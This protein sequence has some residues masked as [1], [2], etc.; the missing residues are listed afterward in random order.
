MDEEDKMLRGI[1]GYCPVRQPHWP[2][3]S[4]CKVATRNSRRE[5]IILGQQRIL[6]GSLDRHWTEWAVEVKIT[7]EMVRMYVCMYGVYC[8]VRST[9]WSTWV[10]PPNFCRLFINPCIVYIPWCGH[11]GST[12]CTRVRKY[13]NEHFR[14]IRSSASLS[15]SNRASCPYPSSVHRF[16]GDRHDSYPCFVF[17]FFSFLFPDFSPFLGFLFQRQSTSLEGCDRTS[18][19]ISARLRF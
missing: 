9:V 11:V 12:Y 19:L 17:V 16:D 13:H 4:K 5:Q 7:W 10:L 8:T 18:I 14:E 6:L 1:L 15:P 2:A 3:R